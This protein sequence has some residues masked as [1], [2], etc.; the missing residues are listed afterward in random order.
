MTRECEYAVRMLVCLAGWQTPR[1][2]SRGWSARELA[3]ATGVPPAEAAKI[4]QRLAREG[5]IEGRRGQGGG[6]RLLGDPTL[7]AVIG[8]TDARQARPEPFSGPAGERVLAWRRRTT[9]RHLAR[10]GRR[11]QWANFRAVLHAPANGEA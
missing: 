1:E 4:L 6:C 10:A 3:G 5:L 8:A 2:P 11:R 7:A 9:V